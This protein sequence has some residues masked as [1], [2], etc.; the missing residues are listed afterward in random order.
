MPFVPAKQASYAPTSLQSLM[1]TMISRAY[2]RARN[3]GPASWRQSEKTAD[4]ETDQRSQ[5]DE[6]GGTAFCCCFHK[7][8]SLC[9]P[10][11]ASSSTPKRGE[12]VS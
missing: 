10:A 12:R 8:Y 7:R 6:T 1:L 2:P 11:Q 9:H 4:L 5:L 3:K